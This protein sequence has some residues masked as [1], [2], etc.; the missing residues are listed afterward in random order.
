MRFSKWPIKLLNLYRHVAKFTYIHAYKMKDHV[1][2]ITFLTP[3]MYVCCFYTD[4]GGE[5]YRGRE[6]E[7]L[8]QGIP[9]ELRSGVE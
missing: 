8:T 1:Q 6:R 4:E 7:R 9:S 3:C 2:N 5:G